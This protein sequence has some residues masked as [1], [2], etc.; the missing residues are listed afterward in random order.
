MSL[1]CYQWSVYPPRPGH[2]TCPRGC[3]ECREHLQVVDVS[4]AS[5]TQLV[6][7]GIGRL[8]K[9]LSQRAD[10]EKLLGMRLSVMKIIQE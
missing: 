4:I 10:N 8:L 1:S 7:V 2:P 6:P 3:R 5:K 9:W